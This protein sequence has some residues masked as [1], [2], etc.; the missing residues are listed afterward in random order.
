MDMLIPVAL[1]IGLGVLWLDN[2]SLKRRLNATIFLSEITYH[3]METL[4]AKAQDK[5]WDMKTKE[6]GE[7]DVTF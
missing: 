4:V 1:V 7:K 5:G 3:N 6:I 2:R